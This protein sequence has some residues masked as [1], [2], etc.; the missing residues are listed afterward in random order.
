M[1]I[2][3]NISVGSNPDDRVAFASRGGDDCIINVDGD[4]DVVVE[5]HLNL[6]VPLGLALA[7]S[8]PMP[9]FKKALRFHA[10]Q[11]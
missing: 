7:R 2:K 6:H 5:V 10:F 3:I 8:T 11:K 9:V 1:S 4:G